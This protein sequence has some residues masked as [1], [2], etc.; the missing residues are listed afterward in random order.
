MPLT[1]NIVAY[2]KGEGLVDYL[3]FGNQVAITHP[4]V[5]HIVYKCKYKFL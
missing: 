2:L 5:I 1:F 4:G 3:D